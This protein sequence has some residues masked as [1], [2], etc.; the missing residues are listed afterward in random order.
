M[1]HLRIVVVGTMASNH[2]AGMAWMHMQITAG[3]RRLGHD[4]YYVETTSAWP[5]DPVRRA[6]VCDSDYALRY[7]ARVAE[8]FG[9]GE[10]WAYRRSYSDKV[11][12]GLSR[13]RAQD[14]L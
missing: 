7:L 4:V 11:W 13:A 5:Y 1:K 6:R 14:L 12:F 2:Y 10:R 8:G 9:L 3:L